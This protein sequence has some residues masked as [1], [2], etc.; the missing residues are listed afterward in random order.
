MP[1]G[2]RVESNWP[3]QLRHY[4]ERQR[5][6]SRSEA[7]GVGGGLGGTNHVVVLGQVS[8]Y[9]KQMYFDRDPDADQDPVVE[10]G[11]RTWMLR[12]LR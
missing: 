12:G 10:L 5:Q 8:E 11:M 3:L 6:L 9:L 2:T 4:I 1:R 7:S